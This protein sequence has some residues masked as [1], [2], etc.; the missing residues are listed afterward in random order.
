MCLWS[1]DHFLSFI[2]SF[3]VSVLGGTVQQTLAL[4]FKLLGLFSR[5]GCLMG[6]KALSISANS[7][8]SSMSSFFFKD[9]VGLV[10]P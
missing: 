7:T 2:R 6:S 9:K 4:N 3:P 1:S 5:E 8:I 10:G